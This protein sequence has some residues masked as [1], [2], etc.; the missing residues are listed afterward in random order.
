MERRRARLAADMRGLDDTES[1]PQTSQ[2]TAAQPLT[3][4]VAIQTPRKTTSSLPK[5]TPT[6]PL[7]KS[8]LLL[9]SGRNSRAFEVAFARG[10]ASS[11]KTPTVVFAEQPTTVTPRQQRPAPIETNLSDLIPLGLFLL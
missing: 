9:S 2:Q 11:A 5:L 10:E 7:N 6:T 1:Q 4:R 3:P 8:D